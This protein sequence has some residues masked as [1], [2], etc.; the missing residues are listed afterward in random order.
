MAGAASGI[1]QCGHFTK[2]CEIDC[3]I[4][5]RRQIITT[6]PPQILND[7]HGKFPSKSFFG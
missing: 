6:N 3:S 1:Y 5:R 2:L 7:F 4:P